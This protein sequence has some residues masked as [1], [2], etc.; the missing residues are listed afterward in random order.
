MVRR[1]PERLLPRGYPAYSIPFRRDPKPIRRQRLCRQPGR[2]NSNASSFITR[3]AESVGA[4]FPIQGVHFEAPTLAL[5]AQRSA[6][7]TTSA[8]TNQGRPLRPRPL[9]NGDGPAENASVQ[10]SDIELPLRDNVDMPVP[11]HYSAAPSG[12]LCTTYQSHFVVWGE[13]RTSVSITGE[14]PQPPRSEFRLRLRSLRLRSRTSTSVRVLAMECSS[15]TVCALE[16]RAAASCSAGV[17]RL[18][19]SKVT[20]RKVSRTKKAGGEQMKHDGVDTE[21]QRGEGKVRVA[22]LDFAGLVA[23]TTGRASL[24]D[25]LPRNSSFT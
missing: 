23:P 13:S 7:M 16:L 4:K 18:T 1:R 12:D 25:G 5:P 8:R 3:R 20:S 14:R 17:S 24:R 11:S 22:R 9:R 21:R 10:W 15:P 19:S 6:T 2:R